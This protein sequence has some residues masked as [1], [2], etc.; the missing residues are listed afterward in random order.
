MIEVTPDISINEKDI[1]VSFARSPGPGGQNVNKVETAVTL[2]FD[3]HCKSRLPDDVRERLIRLARNRINAQG[4]LV[5][6]A[7]RFRSQ[8]QNREDAVARL[9]ELVRAATETP[10]PRRKTKPSRQSQR[11]RLDGKRRHGETKRRR[12]PVS[13]DD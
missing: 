12:G 7:S 5:I 1:H 3:P 10:R 2:R 6:N 13:D 9:V 8:L 4:M 11:R